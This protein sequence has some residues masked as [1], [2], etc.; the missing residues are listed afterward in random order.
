[1]RLSVPLPCTFPQMDDARPL[2][3]VVSTDLLGVGRIEDAARRL[4][5]ET[6]TVKPE[7]LPQWSE[8]DPP[9]VVVVDLDD[10]LALDAVESADL[11]GLAI[12]GYYSHVDADKA[13]R[14]EASG[15]KTYPRGRFFRALPELLEE[16]RS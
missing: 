13:E 8:I 15:V 11:A 7:R 5:F 3:W 12:V 10:P 14:A 16:M 4:G 1:L 2:L 6:R 9:P